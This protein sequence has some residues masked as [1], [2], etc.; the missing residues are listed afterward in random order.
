MLALV[1]LEVELY[2]DVPQ[3][4]VKLLHLPL[5]I[6][7]KLLLSDGGLRVVERFCYR[8][9]L[10]PLGSIEYVHCYL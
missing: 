6:L 1:D 3:K 5:V 2:V 8:F 4:Q 9:S 10:L 7:L